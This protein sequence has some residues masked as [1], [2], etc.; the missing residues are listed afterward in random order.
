MRVLFGVYP[1]H[2]H[3][4]PIV[5]LA[6]AFQSAGHEVRVASF[7]GFSGIIAA[8]GLT[9]VPLGEP[10]SVE[11]RWA[12]GAAAPN[13]VETMDRYAAAMGLTP[14]DRDPWDIFFQYMLLPCSDYLRP[15]RPEAADLISFAR[16]WR[17][18]LVVC[19]PTFPVTALA[20]R[21]CGA[22]HTRYLI[23]PDIFAWSLERLT[24]ARESLQAAGLEE[25][26]LAALMRPVAD[27]HGIEIDDELLYGHWSI[28]PIPEDLRLATRTS[29]V[30]VRYLPYS[31]TAPLPRWL[32]EEPTRPRLAVSLGVST[33][34]AMSG[35]HVREEVMDGELDDGTADPAGGGQHSTEVRMNAE[36][37][38]LAVL[39]EAVAELDVEVIATLDRT[40]LAGLPALPRNVR[41]I[42]YVPLTQLL[43]SCSAIIHHGGIGTLAAASALRVPQLVFDTG[44]PNRIT[45]TVQD[46]GTVEVSLPDKKVE[47][48]YTADYLIRHG[49]GV[50][51]NHK[52]QTVTEIRK[53]I[54]QVLESPSYREGAA[55]VHRDWLATP[56][57]NDIVPILERLAAE[58]RGRA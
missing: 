36:A 24:A 9:P 22:A 38:R 46:D 12:E 27:R 34:Q 3:L 16:N 21:A 45:T 39:M 58:H 13:D 32:S 48:T 4:Y 49:A 51:V 42:G 40:Q 5:P 23:G 1:A 56:S 20:A 31:G 30:S 25:N 8:T 43:P 57:P 10:G 6:W 7:T 54:Q 11:A 52:A 35:S 14:A 47:A 29:K 55:A 50:C 17:P 19:D 53:L 33:R 18:D 41:T 37:E 2:A 28:D 15:D 26:P 44:D